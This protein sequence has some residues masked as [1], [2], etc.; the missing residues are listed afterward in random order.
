[1][2]C[3]KKLNIEIPTTERCDEMIDGFE[4]M[5]SDKFKTKF[6]YSDEGRGL[7]INEIKSNPTHCWE[8]G[9]GALI[10]YELK[11]IIYRQ[12]INLKQ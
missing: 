1:M 2:G 4:K 5:I 6:T 7:L 9:E 10:H 11:E 3:D 8:L 12:I